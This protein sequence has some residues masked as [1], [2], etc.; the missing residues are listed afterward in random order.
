MKKNILLL[1]F[2]LTVLVALGNAQL[3]EGSKQIYSIPKLKDSIA[4]HKTVA[5]LPFSATISYKKMPKDYNVE[6]NKEEEKKLATNMQSGMYT[7]LLR[8][9]KDYSVTFQDIERTNALLKTAGI[10]DKVSELTQ[11]SICK[12]LGVDAVIKCTYAYE[13][14]GSEAGAIA[15]TIL[16]G[17]GTGKTGTGSLTMQ[18]YN[19]K[20]GELLWRFFKEMNEDVLG[21]AN[22]VMERMMRKVARNFPY[23]K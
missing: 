6:T 9:Q 20:T 16:F 12:V 14:T 5:I 13:R 10:Y 21:S 3:F 23:E 1:T 17:V 8:K 15:K 18:L 4:K 2:A 22:Q 11:D 19:G 7:Y